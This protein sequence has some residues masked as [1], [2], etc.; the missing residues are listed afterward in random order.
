ME[1]KTENRGTVH[2]PILARVCSP[3]GPAAYTAWHPTRSNGSRPSQPGSAPRRPGRPS[4]SPRLGHTPWHGHH[5]R[6]AC[7]GTVAGGRPGD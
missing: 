5:A 2:G 3:W 7:G 6:G 1:N 4:Q